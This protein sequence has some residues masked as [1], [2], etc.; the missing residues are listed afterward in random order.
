MHIKAMYSYLII[1]IMIMI[2]MIAMTIAIHIQA[3]GDHPLRLERYR[4][5]YGQCSN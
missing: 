1:T 2:L 5:D 3:V 4:E